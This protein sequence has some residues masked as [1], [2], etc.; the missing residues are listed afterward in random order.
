M[1]QLLLCTLFSSFIF[2]DDVEKVDIVVT[3][4]ISIAKD[5][6]HDFM[7]LIHKES[8]ALSKRYLK[9]PSVKSVETEVENQTLIRR[10][11]E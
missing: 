1:K 3:I 10:Y 9:E 8:K 7:T 5:N 4:K 11:M 6:A 2:A